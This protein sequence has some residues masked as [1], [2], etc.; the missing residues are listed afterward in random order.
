MSTMFLYI[1]MKIVETSTYVLNYMRYYM[2][3]A[4]REFIIIF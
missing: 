1:K 4:I 2:V 3:I